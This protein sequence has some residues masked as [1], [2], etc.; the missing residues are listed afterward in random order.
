MCRPCRKSIKITWSVSPK[1][2]LEIACYAVAMYR[3]TVNQCKVL[4]AIQK[5]CNCWKSNTVQ[6]K[7]QGLREL[8]AFLVCFAKKA[9][10]FSSPVTWVNSVW[11]NLKTSKQTKPK[12][13]TRK[14]PLPKE[15]PEVPYGRSI[16]TSRIKLAKLAPVLPCQTPRPSEAAGISGQTQVRYQP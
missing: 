13:P 12:I 11:N 4:Q 5:F 14:P 8:V 7:V 10:L 3:A 15:A 1:W 9:N 16:S 6:W 2:I